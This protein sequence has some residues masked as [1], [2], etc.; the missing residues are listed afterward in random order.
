MARHRRTITETISH[1]HERQNDARPGRERYFAHRKGPA[2][3][4][5]VVVDYNRNPAEVVT[6]FGQDNEP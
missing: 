5:R 3:W 6:A 2:T 1:P 4:L